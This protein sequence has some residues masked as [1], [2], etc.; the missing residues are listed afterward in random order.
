[1]SD[2]GLVNG[3]GDVGRGDVF[4]VELCFLTNV[5]SLSGWW[6]RSGEETGDLVFSTTIRV[7]DRARGGVVATTGLRIL[8]FTGDVSLAVMAAYV[9]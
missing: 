6:T 2:F 7:G 8:V 4:L 1:M 5:H 9:T 3:R